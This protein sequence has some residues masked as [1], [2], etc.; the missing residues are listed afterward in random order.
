MKKRFLALACAVLTAV[1]FS[2]CDTG[3]GGGRI[4]G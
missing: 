4:N 3:N 1:L 2:S